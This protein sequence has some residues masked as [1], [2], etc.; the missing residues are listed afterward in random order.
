[1]NRG[2]LRPM[3]AA[4]LAALLLLGY[5]RPV[6]AA[7]VQPVTAKAACVLEMTS[8]RVLFEKNAHQRLPMASCTKIMT[9]LVALERGNLTDVV[10]TGPNAAGVPGSSIYL[11]K[12]EQLTLEDLLYG[13]MLAS[14]NDAAVAIAE[15]IGGSV[16]KFL[17]L[18][19]A[20][21]Q[22]LGLVDTHFSSPNGLDTPGHYTSAY[23]LAMIASYAMQNADFR[24]IVGTK[25]HTMPY[26]GQPGARVV[27]NKNRLLSSFDGAN[28]VKTG[29]TGDAGRCFVGAAER[30]G[31]Q[32]IGVVLNCG[33]MFEE[34]AAL[35][36]NAFARY[37]MRPVME[38][39][40]IYGDVLT[41]EGV[42]DLVPYGAARQILLPLT[43]EEQDRVVLQLALWEP[44]EAPV[45]AGQAVGEGRA[46]LDGQMLLQFPLVAMGNV[47]RRN[48]L[49]YV[50]RVIEGM[51]WKS[52]EVP[53]YRSIWQAAG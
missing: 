24:R 30:D 51:R 31:M 40:R 4:L 7:D 17:D 13:L 19:N 39:N 36:D 14:G 25:T 53:G 11:K 9:A 38:P 26:E 6:A 46:L 45:S 16:P 1:M 3:A 44:T 2:H 47:E 49:W 22:E 27:R 23:D 5:N 34:T 52:R 32:L 12:G 10:T 20:R 8:H 33:P 41:R 15:Y 48:Y 35:L 21:A 37:A 42:A 43:E 18:M 50:Q 29:Y 28:G